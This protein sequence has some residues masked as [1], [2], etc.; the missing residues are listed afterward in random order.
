MGHIKMK[1]TVF[2]SEMLKF[3]YNRWIILT[4]IITGVFIPSMTI[5]LNPQHVVNFDFLLNQILQ[6]FYLGQVGLIIMTAL[7]FGEELSNHSI[8]TG[9]LLVPNRRSFL[10]TK[11]INLI[12]CE[13][14]YISI[15][16]FVSLMTDAAIFNVSITIE[17]IVKL[18]KILVPVSISIIELSSIEISLIIIS[19]SIVFSLAALVSLILGLGQ[20]LLQFSTLCKFLPVLSVMNL[21]MT[22]KSPI[23][24][25]ISRGI[26]IQ[27]VWCISLLIISHII[28]CKKC[29][30]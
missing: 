3:A 8:R 23:Y 5:L 4:G 14:V 27:G 12:V 25:E 20:L 28:F 6:S 29:I 10:F 7:Y 19:H 24:P 30:R 21:Y 13:L 26:F 16:F 15:I 18:V 1:I 11:I 22:L 9:L 2:K 17:I